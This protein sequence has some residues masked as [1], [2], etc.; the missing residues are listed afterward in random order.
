MMAEKKPR[1]GQTAEEAL[2]YYFQKLGFFVVRDVPFSYKRIDVTDVDLWLYLKSSTLG[3]ERICVDVKS[4][5]TPQ[6]LE[7]VFWSKG[8]REILDLDRTI[9]ATTDN[10]KETLDFG[11]THGVTVLQGKFLQRVIKNYGNNLNRITE[12]L[13][14]EN[15]KTVSISNSN[16]SWPRF[17]REVKSNLLMALN[18]SGCNFL[19][20]RILFL[21]EEF[22][23]SNKTSN[24][25][26][27]LLY[28]LVSYFLITLDYSSR[29]I[30]HLDVTSRKDVL[31]EGFRYGEAGKERAKEI[32]RTTLQLL[33]NTS[34]ADLF[35][36]AMLEKEIE[37]QVS[38]YPAEILSEFF[39]KPEILS[40]IFSFACK[41]EQISYTRNLIQPHECPSELKAILGVLCDFLKV[42]RRK[43]I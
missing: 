33:S 21:I 41:F 37:K 17:Y 12:E 34:R 11:A 20:Q 38:E 31:S 24:A 39:S 4:K 30:S 35:S 16:V 22:L 27:R 8:L 13:F 25:S 42:D 1:K 9:I 5:K 32:V 7:R 15:L 2:R 40:Q 36:R 29:F 3:R 23:A 28:A 10:R 26:I 14:L 6:A 19:L 43:L 18:F